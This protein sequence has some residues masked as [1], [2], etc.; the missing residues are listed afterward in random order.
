MTMVFEFTSDPSS[1]STTTN[2]PPNP[3]YT[4]TDTANTVISTAPTPP[5][6]DTFFPPQ[7]GYL[8]IKTSSIYLF[9]RTPLFS[10][11]ILKIL[12]L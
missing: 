4:N 10:N 11:T 2:P 1:L 7:S 3:T 9:P 12:I 5:S 8:D 6:S